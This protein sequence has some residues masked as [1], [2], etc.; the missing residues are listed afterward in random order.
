LGTAAV[1]VATLIGNGLEAGDD[2][3]TPR[4]PATRAL[5]ID[6]IKV[7][8]AAA[9]SRQ[10]QA[11]DQPVFE[12]HAVNTRGTAAKAQVRL[13]MTSV[14]PASALSRIPT[15]PSRMWENQQSITLGANESKTIRITAQT[16][17]PPE[18][19]ISVSVANAN[20]PGAAAKL[21]GVGNSPGAAAQ[22]HAARPVGVPALNFTTVRHK[23]PVEPT[24]LA[25][26]RR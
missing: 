12:L 18:R 24:A 10:F 22:L 8:L 26:A 16:N 15:I 13:T 23:T 3:D 1:T 25:Q 7:T 17:L 21:T 4:S 9:D 19:L 2:N 6:G 20:V 11:G 5:V 14:A